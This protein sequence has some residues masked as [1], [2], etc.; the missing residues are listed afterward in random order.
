MQQQISVLLTTE[1]LNMQEAYDFVQDASC[2]GIALFIGCSPR[3]HRHCQMGIM[4]MFG[5]RKNKLG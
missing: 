3:L 2:G 5:I 1:K 4:C